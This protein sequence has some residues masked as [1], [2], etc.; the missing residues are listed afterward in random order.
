M[1]ELTAAQA[2]D[3][4]ELISERAAALV[5]EPRTAGGRRRIAFGGQRPIAPQDV[6]GSASPDRPEPRWGSEPG[7]PPPR[8]HV[9]VRLVIIVGPQ[10]QRDR[11]VVVIGGC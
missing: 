10:L 1:R 9:P 8:V 6:D 3:L 5:T 2:D 7:E 4:Y 11:A